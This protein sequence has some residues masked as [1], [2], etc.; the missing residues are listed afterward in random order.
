MSYRVDFTAG[1]ARQ[2]RKLPKEVRDR[3]ASHLSALAYNPRPAG[4][5]KLK[6]EEGYRIRVG[7]YRILYEIHDA[8]LWVLI[9]SVGHRREVYRER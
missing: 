2:L 9:V 7:D 4:S 1:A 6:G 3:L 8:A 5:K